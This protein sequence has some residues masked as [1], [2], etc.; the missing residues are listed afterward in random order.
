M[1]DSIEAHLHE[2]YQKKLRNVLDL[3]WYRDTQ[4]IFTSHSTIFAQTMEGEEVYHFYRERKSGLVTAV[5]FAGWR[6]N[7]DLCDLLKNPKGNF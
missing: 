5:Q 6:G 7:I 3:G 4:R 2:A 1:V